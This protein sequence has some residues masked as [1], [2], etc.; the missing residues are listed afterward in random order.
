[1][2]LIKVRSVQPKKVRRVCVLLSLMGI[3][4]T[5]VIRDCELL[6][7]LQVNDDLKKGLRS[8]PNPI[9]YHPPSSLSITVQVEGKNGSIVTHPTTKEE[10]I[11]VVEVDE[12]FL[13]G[14]QEKD[15]CPILKTMAE[16]AKN[17]STI[18]PPTSALLNVTMDCTRCLK[19]DVYPCNLGQGNWIMSIYSARMISA[20]Y[21]VDFKF[22]C[23]D[24]RDSAGNL[25]LPWFDQDQK[26][27]NPNHIDWP[28][29][30]GRDN[31]PKTEDYVCNGVFGAPIEA[32]ALQI[33]DE[34]RKMA[35]I[36]VGT[37]NDGIRVHPDIPPET[38][39]LIDNVRLDDVVIHFRCGDVLGG[40]WRFDYGIMRFNVYKQLIP[41]NTSSIGIITQPF[42]KS[43]NRGLDQGREDDCRRIVYSLVDY[44]KG[45]AT[46]ARISIHN[47]PNET[48][49]LAYARMVM[50][51]HSISALSS[52]GIF[53][54]I[55]TFGEGYFQRPPKSIT[56]FARDIPR[57]LHN[58][59][60][61]N[62]DVLRMAHMINKSVDDLIDWFVAKE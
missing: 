12:T 29:S 59:H 50:A 39:P 47:G 3:V 55:G 30:V 52:F 28:F 62:A 54:V 21:G 2:R 6:T 35:V 32:M 33:Q 51:N 60:E 44:L 13:L 19:R 7:F 45:F 46:N 43:S 27:P 20:Y 1:M 17:E 38:R 48:L 57:Q 53:P 4:I 42:D 18:H 10:R 25:L 34:M 5:H 16:V 61:I 56:P 26:S 9:Y 15:R 49:P 24:G 37:Q 31:R 58:V 14:D 40:R 8:I 41:T 22:Q 11:L 23:K 36:L